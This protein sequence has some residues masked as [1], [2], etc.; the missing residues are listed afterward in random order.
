[1][2]RPAAGDPVSLTDLAQSSWRAME[3]E[4]Q[5][6]EGRHPPEIMFDSRSYVSGTGGCNTFHAPVVGES[7]G[8]SFGPIASSRRACEAALMQQEQR[9]FAALTKKTRL[10]SDLDKL[11][12]VAEDGQ[13]ALRFMRVY[14]ADTDTGD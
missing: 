8:V 5:P 7:D 1:M 10:E 9:F 3:I 4:G 12:L 2:P 6:V 11:F 14:P 13:V